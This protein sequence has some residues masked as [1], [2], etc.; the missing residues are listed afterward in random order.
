MTVE[1]NPILFRGG[2]VVDPH[3][4]VDGVADVLIQGG[5]VS[6]V[7]TSG[8]DGLPDGCEVVDITGKVL[9]PGFVDLHTHIRTPGEEWKEDPATASSAA[10]RGG[11]TTIC[12]MPNTDPAQDNESVVNALMERIATDAAVRARP[13]GS[14]TK[15]RAGKELAPM[16][17]LAGAGVVGFSDDGD[18]VMSGHVMRQALTYSM[19]VGLPIINHA[20]DRGLVSEWDMHEGDVANRSGLRGLPCSAESVMIARDIQ[21]AALTGGRLHVPH[22]SC[23]A[24][25]ELIRRAKSEGFNVTAEV[26]PHHLALTDDWVYGEHGEVPQVLGVHAYETNAK[27]APPLRNEENRAA[28]IEGLLD[29][30]IDAIATDHAPHASTDKVCTFSE[31]KNGIIG[32]ETAFS[33]SYGVAQLDLNTVISRLTIG[34]SS[35]LR[36]TSVG[37]LKN[38]DLAIIDLSMDW[39]VDDSTL[40]S[41]SRNTPMLD[42]TMHGRV[43]AT[44]VGGVKI[45]D[46]NEQEP[47]DE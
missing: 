21:L 17:E 26:T 1:R 20:E 37:R 19:D 16:H 39:V 4:G 24:S 8:I 34:P 43:Q 33:M 27:M 31:A 45:W 10:M 23:A 9:C 38:A 29:G 13:I 46:V 7:E 32:L 22:V 25:V 15:S 3:I 28:L 11:F 5:V 6:A 41:K 40:G 42:M 36:D 47:H 18:P 14:I 12:L 44:Y 35:I 2:R 30:T